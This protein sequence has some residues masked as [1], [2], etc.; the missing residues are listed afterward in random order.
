ML[1]FKG[2]SSH[3]KS[4]IRCKVGIWS[5]AIAVHLQAIMR[6]SNKDLIAEQIL[7]GTFQDRL[8]Y[9]SAEGKVP[10]WSTDCLACFIPKIKTVFRFDSASN[11]LSKLEILSDKLLSGACMS[12][13]SRMIVSYGDTRFHCRLQTSAFSE[14]TG[15]TDWQSLAGRVSNI[16]WHPCP[17]S[18][19][20]L[21]ALV[22]SPGVLILVDAYKDQDGACWLLLDMSISAGDASSSCKLCWSSEGRRLSLVSKD[23]AHILC[24]QGDMGSVASPATQQDTPCF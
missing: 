22:L 23:F 9:L 16:A 6:R 18:G 11:L 4:V 7:D 10:Q 5:H 20:C 8:R 3:G 19:C 12:P 2:G 14:V 1:K 21:Y 17:P 13:C 24:F 15:M